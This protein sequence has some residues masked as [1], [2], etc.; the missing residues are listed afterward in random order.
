[1]KQLLAFCNKRITPI[2]LI[3]NIILLINPERILAK[4][5][6]NYNERSIA[7][8]SNKIAKNYSKKFCNAIGI[9]LSKESALK[10]AIRE[11]QDLK[12]NPTLLMH[13]T[14]L[15]LFLKK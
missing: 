7:Q 1:M 2:F 6:D 4:E 5:N 15:E 9:G 13:I 10:L 12:F 3:I 8:I 14:I 11:N